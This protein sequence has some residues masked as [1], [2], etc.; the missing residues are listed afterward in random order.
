[1]AKTIKSLQQKQEEYDRI[2]R[3]LRSQYIIHH[4]SQDYGIIL[5]VNWNRR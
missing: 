3:R 1:M 2:F 4:H 5:V